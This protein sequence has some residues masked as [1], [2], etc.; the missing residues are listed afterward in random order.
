MLLVLSSGFWSHLWS[1]RNRY[2]GVDDVP[3][4]I[5]YRSNA[6]TV[7]LEI[8]VVTNIPVPRVCR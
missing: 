2:H 1:H 3:T 8:E 6:T 5:I 7:V 4:S